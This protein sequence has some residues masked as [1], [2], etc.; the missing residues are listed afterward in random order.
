MEKLTQAQ[1]LAL[2]AK[3][4]YSRIKHC[5]ICNEEIDD[6]QSYCSDE[7]MEANNGRT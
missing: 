7:C 2:I 1:H 3:G 5:P 4:D 6:A